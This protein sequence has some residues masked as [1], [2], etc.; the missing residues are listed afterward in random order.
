MKMD[1]QH[2]LSKNTNRNRNRKILQFN[3]PFSQ[4]VKANISI[5]F[6]KLIK[7]T[8]SKDHKLHKIFNNNTIILSNSC[9]T[10]MSSVIK[11]YNQKVLSSSQ[12][13]EIR[14]CN[15][16][17][18]VSCP[19]DGKCL[20]KNIVYKAVVLAITNSHT[21][22]CSSED[23]KFHCHNHTKSFRHQH[24]KND[25]ELYK[26]IQDLK[27][28]GIY[29][30]TTWSIAAYAS[31]YRCGTRRCDLCITEKYIIARSNQKNILNKKLMTTLYVYRFLGIFFILQ[32]ICVL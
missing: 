12:T 24:F 20:T 30:N 13:K 9:M 19:L 15:C 25:T 23:F 3:R 10:N 18:P 2:P 17:N 16:K 7:K 21:Y 29:Y 28:E 5:I 31:A 1:T 26:H 4:N 14:Q 32:T 6:I 27:N 8:F 11:Q 22:Y